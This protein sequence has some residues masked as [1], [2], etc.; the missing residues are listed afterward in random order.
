MSSVMSA[1]LSA[2]DAAAEPESA[3][4]SEAGL[5]PHAASANAHTSATVA[6]S[7]VNRRDLFMVQPSLKYLATL[8]TLLWWSILGKDY[9]PMCQIYFRRLGGGRRRHLPRAT[10]PSE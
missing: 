7:M 9:F 5:P 2:P 10:M 1:E 4:S 8:F 3:G 6:A